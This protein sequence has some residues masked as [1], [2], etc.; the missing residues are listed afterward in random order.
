MG[1]ESC[2]AFTSNDVARHFSN[3]GY[4][5]G[6]GSYSL[7]LNCND[8]LNELFSLGFVKGNVQ[9]VDSIKLTFLWLIIVLSPQVNYYKY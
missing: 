3:L 7:R 9:N 6:V 8:F 4:S 2:L 5:V 1:K